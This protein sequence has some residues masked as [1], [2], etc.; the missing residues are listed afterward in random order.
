MQREGGKL[1][2][3]VLLSFILKALKMR[4]SL[5]PSSRKLSANV[6]NE[7][8]ANSTNKMSIACV[9]K[10]NN[11]GE[12]TVVIERLPLLPFLSI[13]QNLHRSFTLPKGCVVTEE[14]IAL[15][16]VKTLGPKKI[17]HALRPGE[18]RAAPLPHSVYSFRALYKPVKRGTLYCENRLWNSWMRGR[19]E[20]P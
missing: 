9:D 12:T 2:Q 16:R 1:F 6:N 18:F 3:K 8:I 4:R 11:N 15:R 19:K 14:S 10:E 7:N 20:K 17:F 5:A 13:P